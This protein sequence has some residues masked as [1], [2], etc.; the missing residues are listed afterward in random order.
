[1]AASEK[2]TIADMNHLSYILDMAEIFGNLN[3]GGFELVDPQQ[4]MASMELLRYT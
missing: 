3:S 1:M 2:I 4:M